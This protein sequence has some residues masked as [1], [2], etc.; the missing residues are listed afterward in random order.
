MVSEPQRSNIYAIE[1]NSGYYGHVVRIAEDGTKT[2]VA[3]E[4]DANNRDKIE[5]IAVD[6]QGNIY[7]VLGDRIVKYDAAGVKKWENDVLD[8]AGAVWIYGI[9]V[10]VHG[11][12]FAADGVNGTTVKIDST[13]TLVWKT[14]DGEEYS[15]YDRY[16]VTA[17]LN[18]DVI[19]SRSCIGSG[20]VVAKK[21]GS[22]GEDVW[23]YSYTEAK[24]FKKFDA[25]VAVDLQGNIYTPY[26]T[27]LDSAGN[28][29]WR[30]TFDYESVATDVY[31][32]MYACE[33]GLLVKKDAENA[34]NQFCISKSSV[35]GDGVVVDMKYNVYTLNLNKNTGVCKFVQNG[36]SILYYK[37]DK[38]TEIRCR[39]AKKNGTDWYAR[40]L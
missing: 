19:I 32:N 7:A 8:V 36:D 26:I 40:S 21:D 18:G 15:D 14:T 9:A 4:D 29:V 12:V 20:T 27:K 10:D 30:Y 25:A 39:K 1:R 35:G 33:D 38:E 2:N 13:G 23:S 37:D 34:G 31:G 17:D 11:N 16:N 3:I 6:T 28:K 5:V 24:V 22:T